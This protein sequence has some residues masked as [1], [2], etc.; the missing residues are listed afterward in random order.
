MSGTPQHQQVIRAMRSLLMIVI[1]T[2]G[3]MYSIRGRAFPPHGNPLLYS[4]AVSWLI[5]LT[6]AVVS[7]ALFFRVNPT[8]FSLAH[9]EKQGEIYNRA[10]IRAFRWVLFHSPL[11]W[12]SPNVHLKAGRADCERVLRELKASEAVHWLTC[13]VSVMVAVSYLRHDHAVYGCV[14]LLV[15]IPFDLYPIMLQRWN[16]GRVRRVLERPAHT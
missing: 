1:L 3:S 14:M 8:L 4:L 5:S 6:I 9:W 2:A 15:R 10:D 7:S 16:R 11:G 12:I 13:V